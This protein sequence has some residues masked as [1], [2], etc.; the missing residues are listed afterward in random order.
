MTIK[1]YKAL[2]KQHKVELGN[3]SVLNGKLIP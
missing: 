1:A 2:N 3:F